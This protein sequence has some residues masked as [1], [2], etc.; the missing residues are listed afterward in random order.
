MLSDDGKVIEE[1]AKPEH[2]WYKAHGREFIKHY[3]MAIDDLLQSVCTGKMNPV[4][5]PSRN[6]SADDLLKPKWWEGP[7]KHKQSPDD[8]P[9]T[10]KRPNMETNSGK[11]TIILATNVKCQE[12]A[13]LQ[14]GD[15]KEELSYEHS[16]N[17]DSNKTLICMIVLNI[18]IKRLMM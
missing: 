2:F 15:R 10:E 16:P 5:Q 7:E 3:T 6:C 4:D 11:R 18:H 9:Q 12:N 8:W 1:Q 13:F 14:K 17:D